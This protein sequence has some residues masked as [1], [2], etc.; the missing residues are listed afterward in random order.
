L[1]ASAGDPKKRLCHHTAQ[2]ISFELRIASSCATTSSCAA[3][4]LFGDGQIGQ[5]FTNTSAFLAMI[6]C[7]F[8]D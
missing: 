8:F 5:F 1:K 3:A 6:V 7:E 2:S 4:D